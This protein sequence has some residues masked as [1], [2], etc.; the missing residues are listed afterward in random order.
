LSSESVPSDNGSRSRSKQVT[1]ERLIVV[2]YILAL[3]M[4]PIGFAIG[5]VLMLSPSVRSRHGV[6]I[7][8]V[9]I[10]AAVIWALMISAGAL[11]DTNQGY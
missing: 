1:V 3:A 7:V 2:G 8:L 5:L 4:P 11:T 9:S 10:V 6:W